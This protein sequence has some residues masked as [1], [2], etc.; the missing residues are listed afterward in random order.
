[1]KLITYQMVTFSGSPPKAAMFSWTQCSARR[2]SKK[3]RLVTPA[4]TTC[5]EY[6]NPHRLRR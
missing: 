4:S 6:R 3:P 2:W 5:C 1:M